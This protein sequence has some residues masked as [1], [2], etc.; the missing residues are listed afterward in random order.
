[1]WP[2]KVKRLDTPGWVYMVFRKVICD[3]IL[4]SFLYLD[5]FLA[6][7][8]HTHIDTQTL[9]FPI[10]DILYY[11]G[12]DSEQYWS[13]EKW[14]FEV[15]GLEFFFLFGRPIVTVRAT[16]FTLPMA[17]GIQVYNRIC[18][19]K[20]HTKKKHGAMVSCTGSNVANVTFIT[21]LSK[22]N[23]FFSFI[24]YSITWPVIHWHFTHYSCLYSKSDTMKNQSCHAFESFPFK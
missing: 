11:P 16:H 1:M 15:E 14:N 4:Y 21:R 24:I 17:A 8:T 5:P 6:K 22:I 20:K 19:I 10:T 2:R 9:L 12:D 3:Q 7:I 23:I 18:I 13:I